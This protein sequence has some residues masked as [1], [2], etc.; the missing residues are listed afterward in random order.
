MFSLLNILM[1]HIMPHT[2][3]PHYATRWCAT[4]RHTLVRHITPPLLQG[5]LSNVSLP[6]L[7]CNASTSWVR[8][9]LSILNSA[10]NTLVFSPVN[11]MC[12]VHWLWFKE[13]IYVTITTIKNVGNKQTLLLIWWRVDDVIFRLFKSI[14]FLLIEFHFIFSISYKILTNSVYYN[15]ILIG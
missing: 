13:A 12:T 10:Q 2:G 14:Y 4:L 3:A 9:L 6:S 15:C 11:N 8:L 1:C 5:E 7:L